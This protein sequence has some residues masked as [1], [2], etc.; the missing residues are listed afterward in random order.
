[1]GEMPHGKLGRIGKAIF[2]EIEIAKPRRQCG[3][4]GRPGRDDRRTQPAFMS[5]A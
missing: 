5:H 2:G 3:D 4:D 1:M